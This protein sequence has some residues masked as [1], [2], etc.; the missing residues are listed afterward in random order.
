ML[1]GPIAGRCLVAHN[2]ALKLAPYGRWTLRDKAAQRRLALLQGLPQ[3][4]LE[5][6]NYMLHSL[7]FIL[8]LVFSIN[9]FAQSPTPQRLVVVVPASGTPPAPNSKEVAFFLS[10]VVT[11]LATKG[12]AVLV[13]GD[14]AQAPA[15]LPRTALADISSFGPVTRWR[16]E[17]QF[18]VSSASGDSGQKYYFKS[19][20]TF[21][22]EFD[23]NHAPRKWSGQLYRNGQIIWAKPKQYSTTFEY[24]SVFRQMPDGKLCMLYFD[25]PLGC[26]CIG[27]YNS[28]FSV[29]CK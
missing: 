5:I 18:E 28:G 23:D 4:S 21:R 24:W 9:T 3:I 19:D 2:P 10:E 22:A 16:G 26:E 20:G 15:W 8:V 11:V 27:T 25:T 29:S 12:G 17:S 1:I 14:D 13:S 7:L 6:A